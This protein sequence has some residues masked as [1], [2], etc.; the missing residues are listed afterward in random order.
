MNSNQEEQIDK[1]ED[2]FEER[3]ISDFF[4]LSKSCI[5]DDMLTL[6][7]NYFNNTKSIDC[8][9]SHTFPP[10]QFIFDKTTIP[11]KEENHIDTNKFN[12]G[13]T[14][15]IV[16]YGSVIWRSK[17]EIGDLNFPI[18]HKTSHMIF[19]D[20]NPDLVGQIAVVDKVIKTQGKYKYS[21][22]GVN[23]TAWY[24]ENQLE[25]SDDKSKTALIEGF[26]KK[27]KNVPCEILEGTVAA[28]NKTSRELNEPTIGLKSENFSIKMSE[29]WIGGIKI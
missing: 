14:V 16:N 18:I 9:N 11:V 3:D 10:K 5:S 7:K 1:I 25:L 2:I 29:D 13:D 17:D 19:Y 27:H 22:K 23:K 8:G 6:F 4:N 15:I 21:L 12:I 26:I 20:M 24:N 28:M